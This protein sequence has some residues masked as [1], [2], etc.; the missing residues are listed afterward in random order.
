MLAIE[1][2]PMEGESLTATEEFLSRALGG[3]SG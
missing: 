2:D 1:V 3:G